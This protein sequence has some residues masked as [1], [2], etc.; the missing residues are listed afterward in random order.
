MASLCLLLMVTSEETDSLICLQSHKDLKDPSITKPFVGF[1]LLII[2]MLGVR[3]CLVCIYGESQKV[4]I[5]Y[6]GGK[7]EVSCALDISPPAQFLF[8][9]PTYF[10]SLGES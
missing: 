6:V 9:I 7:F 8:F 5:S 2:M 10:Q 3:F 1:L 4:F